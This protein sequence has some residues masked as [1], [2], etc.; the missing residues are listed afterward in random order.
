[1][2]NL[3]F[4]QF[5]RSFREYQ[6]LISEIDSEIKELY[7]DIS[8]A[9]TYRTGDKIVKYSMPVEDQAL[10]IIDRK[11]ILNF[12]RKRI[13]AQYEVMKGF[14][15]TLNRDDAEVV[16]GPASISLK[17]RRRLRKMLESYLGSEGQRKESTVDFEAPQEDLYDISLDEYD[18][19]VDEYDKLVDEMSMKELFE[20][21]YDKE[22][23]M[24]DFILKRRLAEE[25][26][27]GR[28][29]R[30]PSLKG[31]EKKL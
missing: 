2:K 16:K 1:M 27:F 18:L 23:S 29:G 25:S 30:K 22:D 13:E 11:S 14:L 19:P 6:R 5:L 12:S 31:G 20:G 24:D 4:E 15:E 10:E 21:F 17:D 3:Q 9:L 28:K 26:I 7:E 8:P